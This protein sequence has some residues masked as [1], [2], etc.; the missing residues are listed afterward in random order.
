MRKLTP[1][2]ARR[3]HEVL[4]PQLGYLN[5][6]VTR[7]EKTGFYHMDPFFQ[8]VVKTRDAMHDLVIRL[9][10]RGCDDR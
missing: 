9:H 2:E 1:T 7:M 6:L 3:L 8:R 5:R 4:Q 10:Y